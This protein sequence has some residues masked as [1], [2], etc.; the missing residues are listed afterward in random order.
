MPSGE[1]R[2]GS[3]L[4]NKENPSF[5]SNVV[6]NTKYTPW[7]FLFKNLYEQFQ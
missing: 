6:C 7:S 2:V 3:V 1:S 5:C 4:V